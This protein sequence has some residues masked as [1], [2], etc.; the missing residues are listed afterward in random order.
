[1]LPSLMVLS[2]VAQETRID[3]KSLSGLNQSET[4]TVP[5]EASNKDQHVSHTSLSG[6]IYLKP[7]LWG[8]VNGIQGSGGCQQ[9]MPKMVYFLFW[10]M[11]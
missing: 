8:Q 3:V 11:K 9:G 7:A 10:K 4:K 6:A 5:T 1:M 2:L